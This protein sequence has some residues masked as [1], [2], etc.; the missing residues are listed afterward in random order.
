MSETGATPGPWHGSVFDIE[1]YDDGSQAGRGGVWA[2]KGGPA[3]L[4]GNNVSPADVQLIASAPDLLAAL[5]AQGH[6][7]WTTNSGV[8]FCRH[9]MAG[10]VRWPCTAAQAIAKARGGT[11]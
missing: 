7:P 3:I 1:T 2:G 4:I 10:N 11:V 9:C 8:K 5:E 6:E